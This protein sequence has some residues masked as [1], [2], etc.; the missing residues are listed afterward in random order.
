MARNT[1]KLYT[2]LLLVSGSHEV[3]RYLLRWNKG[4]DDGEE[5][6]ERVCVRFSSWLGTRHSSP[7]L[8]GETERNDLSART[9]NS[10]TYVRAGML[11]LYNRYICMDG[12]KKTLF[13]YRS[14]WSIFFQISGERFYYKDEG[15]ACSKELC[16]DK[17]QQGTV[18]ELLHCSDF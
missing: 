10:Y 7:E 9:T 2:F 3:Q 6:P 13:G 5:K 8:D 1:G 16:W 15:I 4:S 14:Y 17:L 11:I 18:I 12:E